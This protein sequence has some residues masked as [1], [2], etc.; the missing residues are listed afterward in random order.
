M[1][2]LPRAWIQSLAGKLLLLLLSCFSRVR[3]CATPEMAAHQASPPLGFSGSLGKNTGVGC[4]F[5]QVVRSKERKKEKAFSQKLNPSLQ[6]ERSYWMPRSKHENR[7]IVKAQ[8]S[9]I[10]EPWT[11]RGKTSLAVQWLRLH[12]PNAG[13]PGS[14]P[15]QGTRSHMWQLRAHMLL[16]KIP[17]TATKVKDPACLNWDLAWP[18]K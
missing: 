6:I 12:A 9:R 11:Q 14:I 3:L 18:N 13:G 4:H 7:C 10:S 16:L 2:S 1:F 8:L 17:N 5:P 15:G